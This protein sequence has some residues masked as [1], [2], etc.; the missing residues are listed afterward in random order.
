MVDRS[1][2]RFQPLA[3]AV[4]ARLLDLGVPL[5]NPE[6]TPA[7]ILFYA[8][9]IGFWVP[10]LRKHGLDLSSLGESGQ[11][12]LCFTL[13][14]HVQT[15]GHPVIPE[16]V[17]ERQCMELLTVFAHGLVPDPASE[18]GEAFLAHL[19]RRTEPALDPIHRFVDAMEAQARLEHTLPEAPTAV[20]GRGVRL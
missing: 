12:F 20:G 3:I 18:G 14:D 13:D 19:A 15:V 7:M 2:F 17:A 9:D 6:K 1:L 5:Q 8:R 11:D 10:E 16:N 4:F